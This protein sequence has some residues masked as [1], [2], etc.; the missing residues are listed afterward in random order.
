MTT[1]ATSVPDATALARL[2][3]IQNSESVAL[4]GVSANPIRS[5]NFVAS[6]LVRTPFRTYPVNPAYDEVLGLQ[7]YDTLYD[8]PEAPDIVD[9][10]RRHEAIPEV[11]DQAIEVGAKV[12]WLQLGLRHEEAARKAADAGLLVVQDRCLKIEHARFSGRLHLAGFNTGVISSKR[13]RPID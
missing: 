10:F 2:Q 7:T 9:V 8:L 4:V 12:V 3:I 1:T 5:S 11:V 13:R 6:Y